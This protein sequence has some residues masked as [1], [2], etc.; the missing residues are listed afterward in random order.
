MHGYS[1][2]FRTLAVGRAVATKLVW[3]DV[4]LGEGAPFGGESMPTISRPVR[5]ASSHIPVSVPREYSST[6]V[7]S[8]R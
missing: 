6:R 7:V 5:P 2:A 8:G 4:G 1:P 3:R